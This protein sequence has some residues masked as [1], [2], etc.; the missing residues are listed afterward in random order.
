MDAELLKILCCPET[1]QQLH[2]VPSG[3]LEK[4]NGQISSGRLKNRAGRIVREKLED[5]LV[6]ADGRYIYPMYQRIPML[7]V[8][9]ALPIN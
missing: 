1:H 9:E 8:D 5:G 7:L 6:R 2:P 3:L 4:I